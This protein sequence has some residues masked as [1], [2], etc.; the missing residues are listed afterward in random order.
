MA[1]DGQTYMGYFVYFMES[2]KN[3]KVYVGRTS[4]EPLIRV[5]EHNQSGNVWSKSNRP[6]K[7]LYYEKFHCL[8][9]ASEKELF[10]K[11]GFGRSIKSL[12]IEHIKKSKIKI[13]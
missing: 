8:K 9:D 6:F 12:I 11:T 1:E 4:K 13:K 7:L 5:K 2:D 10:Y 3:G